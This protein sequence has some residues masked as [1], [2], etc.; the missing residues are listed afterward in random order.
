M[1]PKFQYPALCLFQ[2]AYL[3]GKICQIWAI[4][5]VNL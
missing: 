4:D 3:V 5:Q 1:W 2:S